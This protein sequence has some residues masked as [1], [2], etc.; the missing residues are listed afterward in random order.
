M[1]YIISFT[2]YFY[3]FQMDK[4]VNY[5]YAEFYKSR[6]GP[7]TSIIK[8]GQQLERKAADLNRMGVII[9]NVDIVGKIL[10]IL[11]SY[12]NVYE[13]RVMQL[14]TRPLN[15]DQVY[16]ILL[17]G[18]HVYHK[19]WIQFWNLKMPSNSDV[20]SHIHEKY[21]LYEKMIRGGFT[22]EYGELCLSILRTLQS[23]WPKKALLKLYKEK[24]FDIRH[25]ASLLE[26]IEE[27]LFM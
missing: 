10:S 17:R 12:Y 8:Y 20:T 16:D 15:M 5:L 11:P 13:Q 4:Y 18:E 9:N 21:S 3:L 22:I 26:R 24:F 23:K 14:T 2:I 19:F 1:R 7:E 6:C 27:R 25:L